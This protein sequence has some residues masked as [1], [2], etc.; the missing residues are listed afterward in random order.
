VH[1]EG[2]RSRWRAAETIG[3]V[4][5]FLEQASRLLVPTGRA[6]IRYSPVGCGKRVLWRHFF[7]DRMSSRSGAGRLSN[8]GKHDRSNPEVPLNFAVWDPNVESCRTNAT[9]SSRLSRSATRRAPAPALRV[10][11]RLR[12]GR[13]WLRR[14]TMTSR[15][16]P[17]RA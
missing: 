6:Y 2:R 5:R 14:P 13:L 8:S 4:T 7:G 10:I 3:T 17:I 1:A 9:A 12:R 11:Y 15:P 16:W